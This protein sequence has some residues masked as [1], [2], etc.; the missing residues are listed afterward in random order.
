MTEDPRI[1][2]AVWGDGR[3]LYDA[4]PYLD[5]IIETIG[6]DLVLEEHS[7]ALILAYAAAQMIVEQAEST[8]IR[9]EETALLVVRTLAEAAAATERATDG[10]NSC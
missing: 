6:R 9:D 1:E 3:N 4:V 5:T 8:G 7:L 2:E 10:S